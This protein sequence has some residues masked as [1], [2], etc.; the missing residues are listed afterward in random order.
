MAFQ[1]EAQLESKLVEQLISQG[2]ERIQIPDEEQLVL[3]FRQQVNRFNQDKLNGKELTDKEFDR[4]MT[5]ISGKSIF[6]SAK[7]LRDKQEIEREDGT[8]L[9]VELFNTREWCKNKF[10]VSTQTTV[11][12]TYTS[13][14]DVTI[15]VNGLPV[16]QVELKKRGKDFSE[17]FNQVMRYRRDAYRGLFRFIQIFVVSNGV[18][19]KYFSNSDKDILFSHTFFWSDRD[20]KLI[21]NLQEFTS[22]FL[23]RCRL[24]KMIARYMILNE[25]DQVLMVMRPYQVYAVEALINRATETRNNGFIWHTTGSGK[26]LTSF[27]AS[28]VLAN[29][30]GIAKV[31]F[32][33]DRRDLDSQTIA[34]FN[35][36]EKDS[37]DTTDRTEKLV[38]QFKDKT[39]PFIVT[40]IQKMANAI[41][42]PRYAKVMDQYRDERVVF[43]IDEC[44]R[45]QFGEMHTMIN[46]HFKKAQYFGFTG[47]PRFEENK[48]Q[49]GRTTADL[50][51]KMLHSYLIKDAIRDGNV[52]GFSVEHISTFKGAYDESDE[53]LAEAINTE[54]VW[55]EEER[56]K[57]V[58]RHI[59]DIHGRKTAGGKYT[60]IFAVQSI[61]MAVK[62]YD[63]VRGANQD[64]LKIAGIFT[65]NANEESEGADE[66]SRESLDRMI[67]DYNQ[68][69]DTNYSTETF[70]S[71]FTDVSKKVKSAQIDILIVVNMFLTGFDAK[72]LNTLY[73]DKN[74]KYHDLIQA[75]SRTNRVEKKSKPYGNI[76]NY[77][78]LKKSTDEAIKLFSQT[79]TADDVLMKP[80]DY[81]EKKFEAALTDLLR[82]V[83]TPEEVDLLEG[84][85]E[86]AEFILAF[87]DLTR[88]LVRLKTF[89]EFRFDEGAIG[90]DEQEYLDFK[91]KYLK[92]VDEAR[93]QKEK[94]SI[95]QDID[96]ELELMHSDKI[97]VDYILNLIRNIDLK[98]KDNLPKEIKK[99]EEEID[100]SDSP[101]LRKKIDLLKSF[102]N[103]VVPDLP[104]DASI[105]DEYHKHEEEE[106]EREIDEFA[107]EVELPP[108][109]IKDYIR[110]YEYSYLLPKSKI[111]DSVKAPFI[112]KRKL[113]HRIIDFI[114]DNTEKY[115]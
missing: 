55:M 82:I 67:R 31:V 1:S 90:L 12:G 62:Y 58:S 57:L 46:R 107:G 2:Y 110:E 71:Y 10:Q 100:R 98:D 104:P 105:D 84:E 54:E 42:N 63:L 79:D 24:A 26:T 38:A 61:P 115:M 101:D 66:H 102:L 22:D 18:D 53:S 106:R 27:K 25:T 59:L 76:V 20:N 5:R 80:Y 37:V 113:V 32:L 86:K 40:T 64:G 112:K 92:V 49:D 52:L 16:V 23:E 111:S 14:F 9:A 97:N 93:T 28:Q 94:V 17:A 91:S 88:I 69:F 51:D 103:R 8:I 43:I 7:I 45:S 109:Q 99:I 77:R 89:T 95:L 48:S 96:F 36:F 34:E 85:T 65:Y 15:L 41:R 60:A 73:T 114:R 19:T 72:T 6:D 11:K 108:D 81:Y 74:L 68:L 47:T 83:K 39:K 30:P 13:R 56:M 78:N 75:Y 50:F 35:K 3:N 4:L 44:H 87:R 29:E 70:S 33:V 21:T